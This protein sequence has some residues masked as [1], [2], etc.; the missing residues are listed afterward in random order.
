MT[1]AAVLLVSLVATDAGAPSAATARTDASGLKA[2]VGVVG[3]WCHG[4]RAALVLE[5]ATEGPI[6]LELPHPSKGPIGWLTSCYWDDDGGKRGSLG[7]CGTGRAGGAF[8][9]D[10]G[11]WLSSIRSGQGTRL[12]AGASARSWLE[13]GP[14]TLHRG[15]GTLTISGTIAGIRNPEDSRTV[16]TVYVHAEIA[17][18]LRRSGR[19]FGVRQVR[20]EP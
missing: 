14:A 6:W 10:G 13:L 5:N 8:F 1:A 12:E 16:V 19:C 7:L 15:R 3:P 2:R 9:T 18:T 4:P 17:V 20:Q 11:D